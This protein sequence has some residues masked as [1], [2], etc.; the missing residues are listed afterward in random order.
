MILTVTPNT[1]LDHTLIVPEFRA[2]AT[3]RC[4]DSV[5]GMAGKAADVSWILAKWGIPSLA[6]GFAAGA[7][8]QRMETMLQ[9]IGVQ[10]DFT[11]VDGETRLNTV[12]VTADGGVHTTFTTAT[13]KVSADHLADFT[14]R[15]QAALSRATCLVLGGTAAPGVP[16]TFY[17]D[18]IRQARQHGI[19]TLMDCTGP[20]QRAGL[21]GG[22]TF[23]KPNLAELEELTGQKAADRRSAYRL[24]QQVQAQYQVSLV[25]TLGGEGAL[26]LFGD[27][28]YW[29][30]PLT[31]R[32]V[33][34]A[35]AGDAVVAG[36]ASALANGSVIEDGLRLGFALAG[37]TVQHPATADYHRPDAERFLGQVQL[38][39][40]E[41]GLF[42]N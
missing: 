40:L 15:F 2:N 8:G 19:P 1:A 21:E 24:A 4:L 26:A 25:V 14:G 9:E 12:V 17:R 7:N 11:W 32:V 10:T 41:N 20:L 30:P 13:L 38:H 27:M 6:M 42:G 22:P 35:G 29:I 5:V 3:I 34:P 31:L 18:L 33:S 28:H 39:R 36:V 37:A 16:V 23:I